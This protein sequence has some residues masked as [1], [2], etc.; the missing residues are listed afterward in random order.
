MAHFNPKL[1]N[2]KQ[3]RSLENQR[4]TIGTKS[5]LELGMY[6]LISLQPLWVVFKSHFI[7]LLKLKAI[8]TILSELK[9]GQL[10][11]NLKPRAK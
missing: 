1:L 10:K 4:I 6:I 2:R 5:N 9:I 7:C 8:L 3:N 11:I